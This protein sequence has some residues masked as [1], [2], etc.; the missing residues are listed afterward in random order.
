MNIKSS[1]S[2]NI[3]LLNINNNLITDSN[4]IAEM[5]NFLFSNVGPNVQRNIPYTTGNFRDYFNKKIID[6]RKL[7]NPDNCSFFLSPTV[8][9][10]VE[11]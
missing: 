7:I 11:K 8:P 3:K 2:N 5:F 4:K 10:T 9:Q 1:K 6:N